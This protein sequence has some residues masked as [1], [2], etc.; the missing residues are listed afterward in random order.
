MHRNGKFCMNAINEMNGK[1][2]P[3]PIKQQQQTNNEQGQKMMAKTF[4]VWI[5]IV[6]NVGKHAREH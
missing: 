6:Y 3:N 1:K 5:I 4:S 2:N